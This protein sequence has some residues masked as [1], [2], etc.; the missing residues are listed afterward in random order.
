M[1][2]IWLSRVADE[3][4]KLLNEGIPVRGVCVYSIL[5]MPEW[6]DPTIW[7]R[8]GLWDLVQDGKELRREL[9]LPMLDALRAAQRLER[10]FAEF[11]GVADDGL[12][13]GDRVEPTGERIRFD[14]IRRRP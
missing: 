9:Y 13:F 6:H 10:K 14:P 4:E 3:C 8:M 11:R 1:R 7:T 5:G 2:P 12:D